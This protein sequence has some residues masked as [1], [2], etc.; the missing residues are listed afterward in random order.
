MSELNK[1]KDTLKYSSESED[2]MT[3]SCTLGEISKKL[4]H[5]SDNIEPELLETIGFVLQI[6]QKYNIDLHQA[7]NRWY[8]KAY[9]KTY[10]S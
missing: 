6:A 1:I 4:K 2:W 8:K 7:W 9:Y 10:T 3:L 5:N